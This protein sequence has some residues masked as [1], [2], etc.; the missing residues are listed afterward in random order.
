MYIVVNLV[1][2]NIYKL[3]LLLCDIQHNRACAF[4]FY[5][6]QWFTAVLQKIFKISFLTKKKKQINTQ[7]FYL[8]KKTN[9]QIQNFIQ[10][11]CHN[12]HALLAPQ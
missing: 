9:E 11:Y 7:L 5:F 6:L 12:Y 10:R 3:A 8:N 2:F 1:I 4:M